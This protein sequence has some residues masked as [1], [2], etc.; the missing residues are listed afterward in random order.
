L[1]DFGSASIVDPAEPHPFHTVF[2][3]TTDYAP[4]EVL[5]KRPYQ[6]P[7]AE[8]WTLGVLLSFLLTGEHPFP[9]DKDV[10]VTEEHIMQD[11]RTPR[12]VS[13]SCLNLIR[14]CL[15]PD[16]EKR[17]DVREVRSHP[18]LNGSRT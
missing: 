5:L 4:P 3:G 2:V 12:A 15:E 17:A 18:W 7:P 13:P 16:P 14:R 1:I 11:D 6:A 8:I 9:R 10:P